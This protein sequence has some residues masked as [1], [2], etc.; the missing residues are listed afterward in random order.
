MI[1]RQMMKLKEELKALDVSIDS[2]IYEWA[3]AGQSE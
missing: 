2:P 1:E 3:T